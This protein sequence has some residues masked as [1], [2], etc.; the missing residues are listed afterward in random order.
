MKYS[1]IDPFRVKDLFTY[2]PKTGELFWRVSR[3]TRAA[4]QLASTK[5][6][7][8]RLSVKFDRTVYALHRVIFV[9][10]TGRQPSGYIDHIDGD[11]TNNAWA[12][13][14]ECTAAE[15]SQ[16]KQI[17]KSSKSGLMGVGAK[18]GGFQAMI[19]VKGVNH[20]LG[21]FRTAE[22][23]HAVYLAAKRDLHS[24]NPSPRPGSA[25]RKGVANKENV[26]VVSR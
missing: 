4:G 21:F 6:G 13:L 19:C 15:N 17:Y 20:Y 3:G 1:I 26:H 10:Q 12:N 16:N 2:N 8:G 23:A 24:F 25:T 14:R 22:E 18:S 7:G 5:R 9:Y 11:P